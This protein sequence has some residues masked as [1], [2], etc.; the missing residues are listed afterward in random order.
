M[1][2]EFVRHTDLESPEVRVC[3]CHT[4][5]V[6]VSVVGAAAGPKTLQSVV[7]DLQDEAAVHH[8]VGRLQVTMRKNDAVV[9]E[10]H[11][12]KANNQTNEGE[13]TSEYG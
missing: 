5:V 1:H 8:T 10:R 3:A 7:R 13:Q 2:G 9:E 4:C 12:L 6:G 11:P